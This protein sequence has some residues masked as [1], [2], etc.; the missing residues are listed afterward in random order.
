M[1]TSVLVLA[2]ILLAVYYSIVLV[3]SRVLKQT[4]LFPKAV[5]IVGPRKQLWSITRASMRQVFGGIDTLLEG[6]QNY[7]RHGKPYI[8]YDPS[9]RQELLLPAEHVSWFASLPDSQLS[10]HGVRQERHALKYLHLGIEQTTTMHFIKHVSGD[11]LARN[12]HL[13]QPPMHAE[14]RRL[15]DGVFGASPA[16]SDGWTEIKVCDA[17]GDIV[18]PVITRAL[19]GEELSR[20]VHFLSVFRRF[21][22]VFGFGTI[23]VGQLPKLLKGVVARLVRSS[24][25]Y[26]RKKT[27]GILTPVVTRQLAKLDEE[28]S[29][30]NEDYNFIWQ[31]A[32]ISEKNSL[33]GIGAR[34]PPGIIAEWIMAMGFAGSSATVIQATNILIDMAN[35]PAEEQVVTRL[36]KEAEELLVN[37]GHQKD[38]N[39]CQDDS[40][41]HE[42]APFKNM[43]LIDS[44]IRESLRFHPILIKGLTKEVVPESGLVLPGSSI[45]M[46]EGSWVGVPVLGIHRDERFYSNPQVYMP[47]RFADSAGELEAGKPT[48]AY[49]GF[50][51]GKHAWLTATENEGTWRCSTTTNVYDHQGPEEDR[52]KADLARVPYI[53][54]EKSFKM[55]S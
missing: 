50:G 10:S 6:Y 26:Y 31:C 51:Y 19:L 4:A 22:M 38:S 30:S 27:L 40:L 35:C 14:L 8:V 16:A 3:G 5:D 53:I 11:A 36:R 25:L 43:P 17:F 33:G 9:T 55:P 34:A 37:H 18:F 45:R 32:K 24:F 29:R 44:L 13:L 47:F 23:F 52:L 48:T 2:A 28:N 46:P 54:G 39:G 12:L 41:W 1:N 42:A 20:D 21:F 7:A 49:L 15:T